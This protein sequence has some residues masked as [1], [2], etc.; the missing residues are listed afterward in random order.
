MATYTGS[1]TLAE[2]ANIT[3]LNSK[4]DSFVAGLIAEAGTD[5]NVEKA[6]GIIK[7][8]M[9]VYRDPDTY[10]VTLQTSFSTN[11]DSS[12]NVDTN[13][14]SIITALDTAFSTLV[15]VCGAAVAATATG[16]ISLTLET[17]T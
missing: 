8:G 11:G 9:D 13:L 15:A 6:T 2:I 1:T 5:T 12:P 4:L 10:H 14:T 16:A 7:I 3:T 17:T